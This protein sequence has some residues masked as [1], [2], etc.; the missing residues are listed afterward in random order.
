M[1]LTGTDKG[2]GGN[3]TASSSL[4]CSPSSNLSAGALAVLVVAYENTFVSGL[5]PYS[6]ISDSQGNTWTPQQNALY[7]PL[8]AG[9][10]VVVRIFT[11][12][13]D[14]GALTTG[15]TITISLLAAARWAFTLQQFTGDGTPVYGSGGVGSGSNTASPTVTTSSIAKD[16]AVVGAGGAEDADSW[17]GDSDTTRGSWSTKQSIG[18]GFGTSGVTVVSQYKVTNTSSGTQTYNPTLEFTAD[19]ILAWISVHDPG[20]PPGS[21]AVRTMDVARM[22]R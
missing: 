18:F 5:D 15:D 8:N 1:A 20:A 7:D 6:S 2:T 19:C 3:N 10:G 21:Q 12:P 22:R 4:T 17:T 11:S 16:D 9:D 14:V 13:Q